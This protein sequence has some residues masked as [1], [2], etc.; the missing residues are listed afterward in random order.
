MSL[1]RSSIVL[2]AVGIVL[3][4][5]A[6]LVRYVI[7]P[8]ATKLPG[9]TDETVH[10]S[11]KA[12]MLNSEALQSG[13]T[14]HA[15]NS[16]VPITVD[17]RLRVTSTHGDTAIMK[18]FLT[19]HASNQDLSSSH[20]YA[21][22]RTDMN[23]S[24]PPSG[25][26]VEPSKG[27]L[28]SAF[29]ANGK[30]DDSYSFYDSTT[31][32]IVPVQ[33]TGSATREGRAVNVYKITAAGPV[34]DPSM[35]KTLPVALP[36]KLVGGLGASLPAATR[37]KFTPAAVAALP[38]P[39]PLTYTGKTTI[40]AYV[41]RQTGIAIDQTIDQQVIAN[42]ALGGSQTSLLPVSV[43]NFKITP[44]S[45]SELGDQAASVGL[46]LTLMTDITPLVLVVIAAALILIAYLRRRRPQSD[47]SAI[48]EADAA[49]GRLVA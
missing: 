47:A 20:T 2:A 26:A 33:Y 8:I 40:V 15:I 10:Y 11:G 9:D 19:V 5:L 30:R 44:A 29:P 21:I 32:A 31:R 28:S 38:D 3:A 35:L 13:D 43:F 16:N 36:K 17:R 37:A 6:M 18:D 4:A 12:T 42:T 48:S 27:A 34:K 49:T 14:A 23:G 45:V 24:K 46:L 1:R 22:D 7:A 39:V 25:T 41:D